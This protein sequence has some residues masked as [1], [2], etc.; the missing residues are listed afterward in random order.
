M[1]ERNGVA[2]AGRSFALLRG[3]EGRQAADP[4]GAWLVLRP[5]LLRAAVR[6]FR[7]RGPS[8]SSPSICAGT[9]K[10]TSRMRTT[11]CSSSPTI[12][13]FSAASFNSKSPSSS[14]TAWE[15]SSP[16]PSPQR[17]PE[18]P[19]AIVTID[20]G[21]APPPTVGTALASFIDGLRG[22]GLSQGARR[23]RRRRPLPAD[24]RR[25]AAGAHPCGHD[26]G[27]AARRGLG[28]RRRA[29]LRREPGQGTAGRADALY[30]RRRDPRRAPTSRAYARSSLASISATWSALAISAS[31]KCRTRSTP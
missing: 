18:L 16:S 11:P 1:K 28:A 25:G 29:R 9:G 13:P 5:L 20:A 17:Y 27:A 23:L 21:L 19:S 3:G 14:A 7:A 6:A 26:L 24:R 31:S 22:P 15:A 30:R 2:E 10:A 8:A 12:S 4:L